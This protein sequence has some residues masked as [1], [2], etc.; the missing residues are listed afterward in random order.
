VRA[1]HVDVMEEI[2]KPST[3]EVTYIVNF[4][5]GTVEVDLGDAEVIEIDD[6]SVDDDSNIDYDQVTTAPEEALEPED[7]VFDVEADS[8]GDGDLLVDGELIYAHE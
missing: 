5:D 2:E 8:K 7:L 4:N 3:A 1:P 6:N